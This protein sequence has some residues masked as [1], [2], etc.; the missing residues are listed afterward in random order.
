MYVRR[1]YPVTIL[2][3]YHGKNNSF[4]QIN[5]TYLQCPLVDIKEEQAILK[6][7]KQLFY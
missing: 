3:K 7:K 4:N 5:C 2:F 1:A 6:D